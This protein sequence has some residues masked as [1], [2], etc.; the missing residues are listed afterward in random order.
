MH[1]LGQEWISINCGSHV[2]TLQEVWGFYRWHGECGKKVLM[3]QLHCL[4]HITHWLT[5]GILRE[6]NCCSSRCV[7]YLYVRMWKLWGCSE[8]WQSDRILSFCLCLTLQYYYV[9]KCHVILIWGAKINSQ[10]Y[11]LCYNYCTIFMG[12]CAYRH[13]HI[14]IIQHV[15]ACVDYNSHAWQMPRSTCI[16]MTCK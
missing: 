7:L 2:W 11:I 6:H 1:M 9:Y 13:I 16:H 4:R 12:T 15:N 14:Y 10:H 3:E 5:V 8:L